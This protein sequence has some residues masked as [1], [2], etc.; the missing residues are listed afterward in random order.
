MTVKIREFTQAATELK[1]SQLM[2]HPKFAGCAAFEDEKKKK[3]VVMTLSMCCDRSDC[4]GAAH[5]PLLPEVAHSIGLMLIQ[6]ACEAGHK[7]TTD[8]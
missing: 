6:T 2:P 8:A 1:T 5:V 3:L 4:S 7:P